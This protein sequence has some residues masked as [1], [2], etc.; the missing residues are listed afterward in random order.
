MGFATSLQSFNRLNLKGLPSMLATN[1]ESHTTAASAAAP[2][3]S[4]TESQVPRAIRISVPFMRANRSRGRKNSATL[5]S[6]A[7]S[8]AALQ[9]LPATDAALAVAAPHRAL[10][11]VQ[12]EPRKQPECLFISGRMADVCAA[13]ERLALAEQAAQQA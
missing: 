13:L 6:K 7:S 2:E 3:S 1:L 12:R 9:L 8:E 11:I 4:S 10:K 5:R